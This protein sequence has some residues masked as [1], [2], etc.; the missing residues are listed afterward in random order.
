MILRHLEYFVAL[1]RE[2]HFGRAAAGCHVS[3]PALSMAIRKLEAE[4]ELELVHRGGRRVELTDEGRAL[5]PRAQATVASADALAADA[6]RLRGRLTA[7]LRLGV[8]PTAVAAVPAIVGP[9][10]REHPGVRVEVRTRSAEQIVAGLED[11][12]LEAGVAYIDDPPGALV[13]DPLYHERFVLLTA[14]PVPGPTAAPVA[15]DRLADLPLC[16]LTKDMQHRRI[17][18]DALRSA[19]VAVRPRVE[20]DSFPMLLALVADGWSTVV[21]HPWLTGR[22]LPAGVAAHPLVDPTVEPRVGLLTVG[23][24]L[25]SPVARALRRS[26][27]D[28]DVQARV[29]PLPGPEQRAGSAT[30]PAPER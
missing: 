22:P 4:L 13:V 23:G 18:D 20:A 11:R 15:W 12:E 30:L 16:L 25:R 21:G 8:I 1:A 29:G 19:G 7:T 28:V 10:Q 26:L 14:A 3:Q 9:L 17:V 5:L 6:T 2:R 24:A 27:A